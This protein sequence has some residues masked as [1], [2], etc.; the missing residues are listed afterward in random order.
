MPDTRIT[1]LL[2]RPGRPTVSFEFFPPKDDKAFAALRRVAEAL[3]RVR[4]DFVTCTYGAGGSTRLRTLEVCEM[5]RGMGFAPVMPHLT[6]V[7]SDRAELAGVA[8]EIHARGFRNVMTLR[9]DPPR[10]ETTFQPPPDGLGNA[11]DLVAFLKQRHPDF[12]AGVGA[13]PETHPE[14]AS[15]EADL[16]YLKSKFAAGA[17]FA[18]TQLFFDNRAYFEFAAR[19]RAAGID[20]PVV[21]GILPVI[22]LKQVQRMCTM[23]RAALPEALGRELE[24]VGGEGDA[25]ELV[26]IE[27]AA[28]QIR[29][30]L[31]RGAPGVHLYVLN[32]S[33]A[34][35]T[36]ELERLFALRA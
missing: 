27:W 9:G 7:G 16:A 24:E 26:G 4:P 19:C 11:R 22:S 13:Y 32:R 15:P 8:D 34:A 28:R 5:L 31:A 21:P 3:R 10:G 12:C 29:E 36:G 14:A 1:E 17:E 35:L 18:V 23:C 25:A 30:L 20:R 6:C 33:R 2:G